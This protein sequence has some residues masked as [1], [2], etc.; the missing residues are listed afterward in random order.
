[1]AAGLSQ[2]LRGSRVRLAL[3]IAIAVSP[4]FLISIYL[5]LTRKLFHIVDYPDFM[6][7]G[8]CT[9]VGLY[10]IWLLPTSKLARSFLL[11]AYGFCSAIFL[12]FWCFAFVCGLLGDCP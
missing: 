9:M 8:L 5:W 2:T 7:I 3:G 11:P 4:L 12:A 6:A 1:M 10:G